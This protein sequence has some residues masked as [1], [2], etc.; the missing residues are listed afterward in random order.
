[1]GVGLLDALARKPVSARADKTE[2]E[3]EDESIELRPRLT[4]DT[5]MML[6]TLLYALLLFVSEPFL[7]H[8][9][10]YTYVAREIVL[11]ALLLPFIFYL[12][13]HE[14]YIAWAGAV[15]FL[16]VTTAVLAFNTVYSDV[17]YGYYSCVW[18]H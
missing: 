4:T 10:D 9:Y 8:P 3:I 18:G 7:E 17:L 13:N 16:S 1:M 14:Y 12:L 11:T 15:L 6:V 2:D 5:A